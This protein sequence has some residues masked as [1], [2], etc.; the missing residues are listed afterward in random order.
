MKKT[1]IFLVMLTVAWN[2][3]AQDR[4]IVSGSV[5]AVTPQGSYTPSFE[6]DGA[7]RAPVNVILMIGDGMGMAHISSAMYAN[8]GE[9]TITNLRTCGWVRTQSAT[10]FTTDSAASGTAYAT[11][12]KSHNSAIGVDVDDEPVA[13]IP[14]KVAGAG[15]V[16]GVVSTDLLDGATPA[17]FF[18]H[19]PKRYMA[20]EIWAD[21]PASKL[22]FFAAGSAGKF[23]E[24]SDETRSA[25]EEKFTVVN[26]LSEVPE[27]AGRVGYLPKDDE[28][29]SK[30]N[31]FG[32]W[33]PETTQFAI[34]FLASKSG[35]GKGFFLMVEGAHIDKYSHGND[36]ASMVR[37]MLAFDKAVEAAVR[38]AE[39]E[40]NTLVV[41]SADHETGALTLDDGNP[42]KGDMSGIFVS[43][44]HTAIPVPLF[45]Y[46]PGSKEFMGV[47]E[48]SDV[49]NKIV[50]LLT[51]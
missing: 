16:S 30:E 40:G 20:A 9:L 36:F 23:A 35:D 47:Q 49:S 37:E 39:K 22:S 7:D 34:D 11:G 6:A 24:K 1:A 46:G 31:G 14:E 12:I 13:D 28:W 32:S 48:N 29:Y 51:E 18:A 42:S 10:H 44:H 25:I 8:G 45:A 17:A 3:W 19:Q 38:F 21:I 43:H 2:V 27:G 26:A 41:I 33:L 4:E 15:I 5:T 50:K